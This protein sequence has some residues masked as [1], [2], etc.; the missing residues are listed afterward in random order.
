MSSTARRA[1][2]SLLHS[3]APSRGVWQFVGPDGGEEIV[4]VSGRFLANNADM[5]RA[6][7]LQ[8][9]GIVLE[10]SFVVEHDIE[11]GHLVRLL[12]A[13]RTADIPVHAVYPHGRHLSAKVRTFV[14]FLAAELALA[15]RGTHAAEAPH[16]R[17]A[18]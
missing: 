11:A 1:S 6:L 5:L 4:Q 17:A 12:P 3:F 9:E 10:P 8:G 2:V 13:Y 18:E 14:D 16:L 15:H 7:A